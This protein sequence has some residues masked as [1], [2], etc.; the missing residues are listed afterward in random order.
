MSVILEGRTHTYRREASAGEQ[1]E[2]KQAQHRALDHERRK[3]GP[4]LDGTAFITDGFVGLM[5]EESAELMIASKA[6]VAALQR[7]R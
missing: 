3:V 1:S 5:L 4:A 7:M 6:L 2:Q